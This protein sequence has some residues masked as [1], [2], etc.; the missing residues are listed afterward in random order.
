MSKPSPDYLVRNK[1]SWCLRYK[2]PPDLKNIFGKTE[3]RYSLKIGILGLL[4]HEQDFLQ[5]IFNILLQEYV[6]QGRILPCHHYLVC[7]HERITI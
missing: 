4:E 6:N 5:E 2:I 1:Y 3:I 7:V